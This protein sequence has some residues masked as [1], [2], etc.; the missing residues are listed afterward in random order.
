MCTYNV[1]DGCTY[2]FDIFILK[3]GIRAFQRR[4]ARLFTTKTR[5][6]RS[7]RV[8]TTLIGRYSSL[9][10]RNVEETKV[11]CTTNESEKLYVEKINILGNYLTNEN[12]IRNSLII[13]E[14]D[15]F[16]EI[17]FKKSVNRLKSK[18]IFGKVD[19]KVTDGS[20]KD[21]KIIDII[22]EEKPTGEI[23][24]GAGTGTDGATI[25]AGVKENNFLGFALSDEIINRLGY[26]KSIV[27]RP[28]GSVRKYQG[29]QADLSQVGTEL[30]VELVLTGS[31]LRDGDQLRLSTEL[32]DLKKNERLWNKTV[33]VDY[34]DIFEIQD[35]VSLVD[36]LGCNY[37]PAIGDAPAGGVR[38]CTSACASQGAEPVRPPGPA[39]TGKDRHAERARAAVSLNG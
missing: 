28:S 17:L 1:P 2:F 9:R 36:S 31:Y 32:I 11:F 34:S 5:V 19:Y 22:V 33:Q 12:V 30:D 13:D 23:S 35:E 18:N 26:L 25:S 38:R 4:V 3:Y 16:N 27:V 7:S 21:T 29:T 39:H 6:C 8:L 15:P 37:L 20:E 10:N 24:A 14:G